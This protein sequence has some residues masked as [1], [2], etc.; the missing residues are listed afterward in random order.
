MNRNDNVGVFLGKKRIC[1]ASISVT[2]LYFTV[3]DYQSLDSGNPPTPRAFQLTVQK[4]TDKKPVD[5]CFNMCDFT[6]K[7]ILERDRMIRFYGTQ[8]S[9]LEY[10]LQSIEDHLMLKDITLGLYLE[11]Y[12]MQKLPN[13]KYGYLLGSKLIG[14]NYKYVID[15]EL[16]KLRVREARLDPAVV[17]E[18][19]S[20]SSGAILLLLA[21]I[22]LCS[23]R[24]LLFESLIDFQGIFFITGPRSVGKTTLA[25]R[26]CSFWETDNHNPVGIMQASS[27]R[28]VQS[29]M[30][31]VLRDM[32]IVSDDY[33]M[34]S[35]KQEKNDRLGKGE[36]LL[37]EASSKTPTMKKIG[38]Q[39]K[40]SVCNA[41]IV[42]TAEYVFAAESPVSR[43]ILLPLS[44]QLALPP[45]LTPE[46]CGGLVHSFVCWAVSHPDE[47][48]NCNKAHA[49]IKSSVSRIQSNYSCLYNI[50]ELFLQSLPYLHF[51]S[52]ICQKLLDRLENQMDDSIEEQEN[53]L[54]RLRNKK[55][56]SNVAK[57]ILAFLEKG[58][59][60]LTDDFEELPNHQGVIKKDVLYL[61]RIALQQC[62]RCQPGYSEYTAT[63]IAQELLDLGVLIPCG[64]EYTYSYG[65][66]KITG[67]SYIRTYRI[68]I[69]MLYKAAELPLED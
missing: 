42:M 40:E 65:K 41:G 66:S 57:I 59:F 63:K 37:M 31:T 58:G 18:T 29:E 2:A 68:S 8:K 14:G 69:P 26:M 54:F 16:P 49:P 34:L 51:G 36:H 38:K 21:F 4:A 6:I 55:K 7:K 11:K 64:D 15:P 13:N 35:N 32:V 67:K 45:G 48:Q 22:M 25:T 20:E 17:R 44:E 53:I 9:L 60:K 46:F 24:S 28:A 27:T 3:T 10:I 47:I 12:G 30:A 43:M 52:V 61:R 62:V 56:R 33:A 19:L 50:F 1:S 5:Y 23:V 39:W